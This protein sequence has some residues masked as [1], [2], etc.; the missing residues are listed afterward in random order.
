VAPIT[1]ISEAAKALIRRCIRSVTDVETL[2]LLA[3][4]QGKT[5]R[6]EELSRALYLTA[7]AAS[8]QLMHLEALGLVRSTLDEHGERWFRYAPSHPALHEQVA[9][10]ATDYA[11]RR[12]RVIE[13][14]YS[15]PS[16]SVHSFAR[17]FK[18]RKEPE[19]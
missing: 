8:E 3:R 18:L 15:R 19:E 5:W 17:A 11:Q 10:L 1:D 4:E 13:Y 6:G 12:V 9:A 14:I 16:D 2:L 7:G